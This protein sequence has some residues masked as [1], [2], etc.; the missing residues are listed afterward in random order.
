MA[1]SPRWKVFDSHGKYQASCH[2]L[3]AAACL[4]GF[5]GP[6]ATI[7]TGHSKRHIVWAEGEHAPDSYDAVVAHVLSVWPAG[8]RGVGQC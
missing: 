7:R 1:A 6:G 5:Y 8:G 4:T 2:E 3:E